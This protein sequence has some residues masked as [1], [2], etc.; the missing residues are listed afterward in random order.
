MGILSFNL[1]HEQLN[2]FWVHFPRKYSVS[3]L[4]TQDFGAQCPL[5]EQKRVFDFIGKRT[6]FGDALMVATAERYL[7]FVSTLVT[8]DK[9]HLQEVFQGAVLTPKD[10]LT[11]R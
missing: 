3:V 4:P 5:V 6:S 1:N 7:P 9:E 10:Y 11:S 8:W 2:D